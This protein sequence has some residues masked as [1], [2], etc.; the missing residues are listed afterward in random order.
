[1]DISKRLLLAGLTIVAFGGSAFAEPQTERPVRGP[2][3][4]QPSFSDFDLDG[5][6]GISKQEFNKAQRERMVD[7]ARDGY[8]M[9]NLGKAS[10]FADIDAN[11]DGAISPEEFAEHQ[12]RQWSD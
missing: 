3:M 2:G 5:N 1:M 6:G 7:R 10:N 4:Q 8:P 9:R 11:A 12:R